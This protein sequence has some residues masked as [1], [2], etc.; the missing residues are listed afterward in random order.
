MNNILWLI[1][2]PSCIGKSTF[3]RQNTRIID[4]TKLKKQPPVW[5]A[6]R[7]LKRL[8]RQGDKAIIDYTSYL[9]CCLGVNTSFDVY[10][11]SPIPKEAIVLLASKETRS[12]RAKRRLQQWE[13]GENV[14][15]PLTAGRSFTNKQ[16][17]HLY[18]NA[19]RSLEKNKIPYHILHSEIEDYPKITK[20]KM[21]EFLGIPYE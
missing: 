17:A 3:I 7:Y 19:I 18:H 16:W 21:I 6:A 12:I 20:E 10:T 1:A 11:K 5:G 8:A 14:A 15:K 2:A 13:N 9:H 4:F